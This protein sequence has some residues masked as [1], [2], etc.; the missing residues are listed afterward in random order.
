LGNHPMLIGHHGVPAVAPENT[1]AGIRVACNLGI[2]G[3]EV[4]VR[5]TADRI[6]VLIHDRDVSRTSN[7]V[8]NV[9]QMTL[10]QVRDLDFGSWYGPEYAG[11]TI[12]TLQEFLN[13]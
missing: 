8:G 10:A 4:D 6:P 12:P 11:E 13:L 2:P 9:D 5:F 3:V 7:G 1:L